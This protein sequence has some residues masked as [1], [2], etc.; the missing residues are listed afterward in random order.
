MNQKQLDH[1]NM[2]DAVLLTLNSNSSTWSSNTAVSAVVTAAQA[3]VAAINN[4]QIG[5]INNSKAFTINKEN[6]KN[7]LVALAL[8]HA[9]AGRSYAT[10]IGNT[11]LQQEL[12]TTKTKLF[13]LTDGQLAP[14]CQNIYNFVN[15]L[16]G[17]LASYG[18]TAA[19]LAALQSAIN[20]FL[21]SVGQPHSIRSGA[22]AYTISIEEQITALNILMKEQL[23]PLLTQYKTSHAI[24]H[25]QYLTDRKLPHTGHR[26]TV[27]I[28]GQIDDASG[29][30]IKNAH[31]SLVNTT[32]K[33]KVTKVDGLYKFARLKPG[34]YTLSIIANGY[35]VQTKTITISVPQTV[36]QNFFMVVTTG[37]GGGGTT[38][39][40]TNTN[41]TT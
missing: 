39:P 9:D 27:T 22:V 36:R 3:Q 23:D 4:A 25:T 15:P 1:L 35:V 11:V 37:G 33:R 31:V 2:Y 38:G 32:R 19:T 10:S 16:V 34:S 28:V 26:T 40:N 24:F 7:N 21:A 29:Q 14:Y 20:V 30:P 18:V 13:Y 12:K 6:L 17:S 5:Q 41:S 8:L